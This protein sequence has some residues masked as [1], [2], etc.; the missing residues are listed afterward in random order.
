MRNLRLAAIAAAAML[1][2]TAGANAGFVEFGCEFPDD[3]EGAA[4]WWDWQENPDGTYLLTLREAIGHFGDDDVDMYGTTDED[5]VFHVTKTVQ[6]TTDFEWISYT[7]DLIDLGGTGSTF[8]LPAASTP[9]SAPYLQ[10]SAGLSSPSHLEFVS[11]VTVPIGGSV[12]FDFDILVPVTGVFDFT[13]RQR[14]I[15]IPEPGTLGL[16]GL[17]LVGLVRRR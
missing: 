2:C 10:W 5:P 11:P 6:N 1:A 3:P 17:G 14:A 13:I 4:H 16:L 15:P 9:S 8:V 7:I 12:T